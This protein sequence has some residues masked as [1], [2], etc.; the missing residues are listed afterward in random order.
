MRTTIDGVPVIA[1]MATSGTGK[2]TLLRALLPRLH[3]AGL[4][5][6]CIKHT[7]HVIAID[8]PG[9]DSHRLRTAGA[10]QVL[11]AAPG[12]W[13]LMVDTPTADDQDVVS[14]VRHL[15][16]AQLDVVL[17]E[18]YKFADLPKIAL[19]RHDLSGACTALDD[20]HVIALA[21]NQQPLPGA[22]VPVFALDDSASIARFI[23]HHCARHKGL[24]DD[25]ART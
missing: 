1:M 8:Q 20:P 9:K 6:G 16:L 15:C 24:R 7:H 14:L 25:D 18:G 5:V 23:I 19:H 22:A 12:G 11:L 2:T 3:D 4:R 17:V 21:S 13:A 10:Q